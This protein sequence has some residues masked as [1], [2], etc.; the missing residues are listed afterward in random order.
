[1]KSIHFLRFLEIEA[2]VGIYVNP[3]SVLYHMDNAEF[4]IVSTLLVKN[5]GLMI[6]VTGPKHFEGFAANVANKLSWLFLG[7]K[8]TTTSTTEARGT[9]LILKEDDGDTH[10]YSLKSQIALNDIVI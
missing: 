7:T 6:H 3:P 2:K 10:T 8:P 4:P 9:I 1:M 5:R